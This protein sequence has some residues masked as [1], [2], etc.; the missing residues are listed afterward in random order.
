METLNKT[1]KPK[2]AFLMP[3]GASRYNEGLHLP[4]LYYLIFQLSQHFDITVYSFVIL[5]NEPNEAQCGNAT[6]KFIPTQHK[7]HWFTKAAK[8]LYAFTR[9]HLSNRYDIVVGLLGLP[10]EVAT[11]LASK[12]FK[13]TSIIYFLGGETAYLPSISYGNMGPTIKGFMTRFV[14]RKADVLTVLTNFQVQQ[15]QK[16]GIKRPDVKVIP[17]G[18][19]VRLFAPQK[20]RF[21]IEPYHFLHVANIQKVKDQFTLLKTFALINAKA[22]SLLRIAGADYMQGKIHKLADELGIKDRIEFCG[23]L[24]QEEVQKQYQW[25]DVLLHTSFYEA[26]AVAVAEAAASGLLICGTNVGLIYDLGKEAV[27]SVEPGDYEGL[28]SA[29]LKALESPE[30]YSR[31]IANSQAWALRENID[32]TVR[33]FSALLLGLWVH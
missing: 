16:F 5:G 20:K 24:T 33:K 10:T 3:G 1:K 23:Y 17:S 15:L 18:I 8:I 30:I 27:V 2:I 4:T 22:P 26:Q 7:S 13:L 32:E 31:L 25:G 28:A 29:T 21:P 6:I 19:D 9:D 11:I 14:C 12:F